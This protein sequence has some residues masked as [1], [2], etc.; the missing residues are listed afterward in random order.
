MKQR[1][2]EFMKRLYDK[3]SQDN[4]CKYIAVNDCKSTAIQ[5]DKMLM[6][7]LEAEKSSCIYTRHF[8]LYM[9]V[10]LNEGKE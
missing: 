4:D 5:S 1:P 9:R 6:L 2:N 10:Q 3:F 7:Y 8:Y